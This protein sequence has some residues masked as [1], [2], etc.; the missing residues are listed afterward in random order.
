MTLPACTGTSLGKESGRAWLRDI[1]FCSQI[2]CISHVGYF[3]VKSLKINGCKFTKDK[4]RYIL[5]IFW[6]YSSFIFEAA[7]CSS[8]VLS[9]WFTFGNFM[10]LIAH[11]KTKCIIIGC[12]LLSSLKWK[13]FYSL[14]T[15]VCKC[16]VQ[17]LRKPVGYN[18]T[19]SF[20][21]CIRWNT[22]TDFMAGLLVFFPQNILLFHLNWT[23]YNRIHLISLQRKCK[24]DKVVKEI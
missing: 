7:T 14:P 23:N 12:D 24:K 5:C 21:A 3:K 4:S 2:I 15:Y 17:D 1:H 22:I 18:F 6:K 11:P 13:K 16:L 20:F 19:C 10:P 8:Y 9:S